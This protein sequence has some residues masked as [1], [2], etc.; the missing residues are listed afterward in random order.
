VVPSRALQISVAVAA[1]LLFIAPAASAARPEHRAAV[2]IQ[3]GSHTTTRCVPF[4]GASINGLQLLQRSGSTLGL[5]QSSIG[6]AVCDINGTGCASDSNC[7]CHYPVFW[8]YWTRA[9]D[10]PK[11]TFSAVGAQARTV[12]DG[13]LDGWVWGRNGG[14]APKSVSFAKVCASASGV[15]SGSKRSSTNYAAFA[16]F[17][18]AIGAAAGVL[19]LRRSKRSR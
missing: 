18:V 5:T 3:D 9:P 11:W 7:F 2:V 19:A 15:P 16:A 17:V 8:G 12:T 14:P 1:S 10:A 6:S 4:T 13:S